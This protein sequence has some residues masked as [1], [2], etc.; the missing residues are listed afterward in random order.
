LLLPAFVILV[1]HI[2]IVDDT[3]IVLIN[4]FAKYAFYFFVDKLLSMW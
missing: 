2:D 4:N 1:L 3:G